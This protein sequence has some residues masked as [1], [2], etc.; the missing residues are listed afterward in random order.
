MIQKHEYDKSYFQGKESRYSHN[1]GYSNYNTMQNINKELANKVFDK[2]QLKGKKVLEL[3]CAK[4]FLIEI[5]RELEVEA[6]GID[7]SEF[8]VNCSKV[9]QYITLGDVRDFNQPIFLENKF[10]LILSFNFL[11]CIPEENMSKLINNL[12]KIAYQQCHRVNIG[13]NNKFYNQKPMKWWK[14]L[15]WKPGTILFN[16]LKEAVR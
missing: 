6:Y 9:K 2:F 5:L 11:E 13:V 8:A 12:N 10:D 4:G 1:G 14:E 15:P 3:G 16:S 7:F